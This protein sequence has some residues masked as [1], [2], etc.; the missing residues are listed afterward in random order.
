MTFTVSD[1]Q[2]VL[3]DSPFGQWWGFAVQEIGDGTA[4]VR[5]AGRPEFFR[6]GGIIQGGCLMTLADVAFWLAA[7]TRIG[8][9]M[10]AVTLETKTNF[11]RA[12]TGDLVC[13]AEVMTAG[14]R[15]VYGTAT[16]FDPQDRALAHHTFT[17]LRGG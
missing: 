17:Y 8:E 6:P 10:S 4:T 7:M 2:R 11:L 13:R 15:V 9:D 5:L 16:T 14:R 12:A 1:A 3:D